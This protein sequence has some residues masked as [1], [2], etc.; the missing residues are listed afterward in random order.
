MKNDERI[1]L[2]ERSNIV[3]IGLGE[4]ECGGECIHWSAWCA[5]SSGVSVIRWAACMYLSTRVHRYEV[6]VEGLTDTIDF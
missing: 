5:R 3:R 6:E 2:G 4:T 1:V